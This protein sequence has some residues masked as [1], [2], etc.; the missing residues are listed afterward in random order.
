MN[1]PQTHLDST[2]SEAEFDFDAIV[3]GAG[4]AGLYQLY[5]LRGLGMR[6][7]VFEAGTGVGG[8]WYWNRYP[9]ARFDSESYSYGYSFSQELLD[10][11]DWSEHFA[12]Q[13]EILSYLQHVADKFDLRKDIQFSSDVKAAVYR[14]E[15]NSWQIE[16]QD[17]SRYT[18]RFL[19]TGIGLLSQPTLPKIPGIESFQ[20]QSFHTS[21]WPHEPVD[22]SGKRVAV[23]GTGATGVQ[24]IQEVCKTAGHLTV[25]QRR[26]NWC[27]PLHNAK[28]G[29]EEM[30]S[31]RES[32]DEIF[33]TCGN[34]AAGFLHTADPRGTFEVSEKE[35][36]EFWEHLYASKGFGI[37]Q[38]N[39]KDVLSDRKANKAMS[40]FV[41][42]KIR[43]RVDNPETAERLIPKDHGFGSR[44]V[45]LETNY[46]ESYN[47]SNV[48][49][50]DVTATPI[51]EITPDGIVTTDRSLEFD[52]IIYATGFDA[53]L[54]SYNRIDIVGA[55][56]RKLRDQW[57]EQLSTFLGIQVNNFPNLFMILGPH[58]LLGNNPR[59]IEFN[60]EWI[61]NLLEYMRTRG[62][63]RAEA[64]IEAVASW[65]E[66]V[67]E[68][69][70]DLLINEIDSWMTGV[71]SNL[72][73]RD[74]RIV[75]RYSGTQQTF[76]KRCNEVVEGGYAELNLQ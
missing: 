73:G 60:V 47:R 22:Y 65:Y 35:R 53:I 32:Y 66:H 21:R 19:I 68:Q 33:K 41:A 38:G 49:L 42:D 55:D 74:K 34:T 15:T 5:R 50:V 7:R 4:V 51:Q 69:G 30:Q 25:F 27:A 37:W 10:E 17:G 56:G 40:D 3:I 36:Y 23:I 26:P 67:L 44:R 72:E 8:T 29:P 46:Y 39:F 20:G 18:S 58:A 75:A 24:T 13:P 14:E 76:R 45:P 9:G 28:I 1:Q 2:G 63:V 31:I 61:A 71:N 12:S 52:I 16:L 62:L 64:T 54:G 6:V 11:W 70:K 57:Q 48:E 59:S 43:E